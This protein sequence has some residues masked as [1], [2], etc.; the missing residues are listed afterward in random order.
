VSRALLV[1]DVGGTWTRLA[2]FDGELGEVW[3]RPTSQFAGLR[4]A[5][6]AFMA[7]AG[8]MPVA[9]AVGIAGPVT[10]GSGALTNLSWSAEVADLPQPAVLL[11]DLEAAAHGVG[12]LEPGAYRQICGPAPR[13]GAT[14]VV[15]GC[16]TGH[17]QAL[18]SAGH[19]IA[20]EGGHAGFAPEDA[21]LVDLVER[22]RREH[23]RV[24]LETILSGRGVHALLRSC[25]LGPTVHAA[26]R[27]EDPVVVVSSLAEQEPACARARSLFVRALGAEAGNAAL[28]SLPS[29]GVWLI[30]GVA[31]SLVKPA[32]D[33]ELQAAFLAKP[34]MQSRLEQIPLLLVED[35]DVSLRG[36]VV[37]AQKL[38]D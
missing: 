5:V 31:R 23:G 1:G 9:S 4:E 13:T 17:G 37:V 11:N 6:A 22:L 33:P 2:L 8:A 14:R 29:G 3:R 16:G 12:R 38:L 18:W 32:I 30:G 20:G 27:T 25:T 24:T 10:E 34:P 21:E 28:R 35:D 7:Q 36:A 15:L 19:V 26:L